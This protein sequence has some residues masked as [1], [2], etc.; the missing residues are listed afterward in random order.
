MIKAWLVP[1]LCRASVISGCAH[2][3]VTRLPLPQDGEEMK[4][5][6]YSTILLVG[7]GMGMEGAQMWLQYQVWMNMPAHY[8]STL[9]TMDVITRPKVSQC[10]CVLGGYSTRCD[11]VHP[12]LLHA[13]D[14]GCHHA[15][16]GQ[17]VS[18][19]LCW[20]GTVPGVDE[21]AHPLPLHAGDHGRHHT[22]QGM[23]TWRG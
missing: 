23:G 15:P 11:H 8:R 1:V 21:H 14:H 19:C 4:R 7:G 12:L 9:E 18:A 16:Q 3:G 5:R 2:N 6:M 20:R 17:S 13:R 22:L 10:L